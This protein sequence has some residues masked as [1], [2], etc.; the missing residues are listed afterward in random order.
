MSTQFNVY[1]IYNALT[2]SFLCYIVKIKNKKGEQTLELCD[3]IRELRK[4]HLHMT[5]TDFGKQLGVNRDVIG[6]ME[7]NRLVRPE[8]KLS[9]LKLICKEFSVNEEWLINGNGPM[10]AKPDTF[11]LHDFAKEHGITKLEMEIVKTYLE[12]DP[13][14][15]KMLIEHF[16]NH[17]LKQPDFKPEQKYPIDKK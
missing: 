3:R 2:Y 9:L 1:N 10:F 6:N 12:L 4:K 17:L 7:L 14:I 15:R 13:D 5:Q 11:N 16:K 8:Q